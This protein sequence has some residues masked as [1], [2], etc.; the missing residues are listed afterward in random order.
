MLCKY[1]CHNGIQQKSRLR[2]LEYSELMLLLSGT[3]AKKTLRQENVDQLIL[4][5]GRQWRVFDHALQ[6]PVE[7]P[8]KHPGLALRCNEGSAEECPRTIMS[9]GGP[10]LNALNAP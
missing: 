6:E 7:E 2:E 10:D 5:T 4:K 3:I 1:G 8:V 9:P